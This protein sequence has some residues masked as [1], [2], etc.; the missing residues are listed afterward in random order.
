MLKEIFDHIPMFSLSK[1]NLVLEQ[2]LIKH[3]KVVT[4]MLRI[5]EDLKYHPDS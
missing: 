3:A 5:A 2:K 4:S 1:K